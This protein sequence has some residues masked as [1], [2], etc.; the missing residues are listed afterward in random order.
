MFGSATAAFC[1]NGILSCAMQMRG[2]FV[3][4]GVG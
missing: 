3:H 4:L 2:G 1:K